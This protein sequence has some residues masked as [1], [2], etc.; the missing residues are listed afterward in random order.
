[1]K[2]PKPKNCEVF[3]TYTPLYKVCVYLVLGRDAKAISR[4]RPEFNEILGAS[5]FPDWDGGGAMCC[6]D[7]GHELGLFFHREY[8]T[9]GNIAHELL[10]A[11]SRVMQHVNIRLEPENMEAFTYLCEWLTDWTYGK[12]GKAV[13]R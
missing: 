11:T 2:I 7:G 9:P 1:M 6:W 13:K 4:A 3:T 5:S 12:I 8:L 10:H